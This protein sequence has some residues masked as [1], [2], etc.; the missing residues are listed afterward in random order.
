MIEADV[1]LRRFLDK[2]TQIFAEALQRLL[3]TH[4][5]KG[6]YN[7]AFYEM[8]E[9]LKE[10]MILGN[11]YGRKRGLM[12]A[13]RARKLKS[14]HFAAENANPLSHG[15]SFEEALKDLI[16]REPRLA[17]SSVELAEMYSDEK[18]F[19]MV[20]SIDLK[21]TKRIQEA[22]WEIQKLGKG[23]PEAEQ[24]IES[25][26]E[27][28]KWYAAIVYRNNVSNSYT[29]GRFQQAS[30]PDVSDVILG[31]EIVGLDDSRTRQNHRDVTGFIAPT[32][33]PLWKRVKPPLGHNCRHGTIFI[34][35]WDAESLGLLKDGILQ[36]RFPPNFWKGGPDPGFRIGAIEF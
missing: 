20:R 36:H 21:L 15:V 4:L 2:R 25:T 6:E 28:P 34:S 31:L 10:T 1:E 35:R 8:V 5:G 11:L 9:L 18:V 13:D 23:L 17:K 19:G 26:A 7:E 14:A 27:Y 22:V 29:N 30:D 12:E 3:L 33:S 16:E 32:D 24:I